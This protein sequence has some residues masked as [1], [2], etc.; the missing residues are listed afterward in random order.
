VTKINQKCNAM[1]WDMETNTVSSQNFTNPHYREKNGKMEKLTS[2]RDIYEINANMAARRLRARILAVL[3]NYFVDD[4]INECKKTLAGKNDEPLADR[5]KRMIVQ[6]EKVGVTQE[7]IEKRSKCD[8][9]ALTADDFVDYVGIYN[10]LKD[11][12]SSI[13]DWFE[14]KKQ[15]KKASIVDI[16]D[17]K[18]ESK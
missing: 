11:K 12:Q 18:T 15:E 14:V 10:S 2:D 7:M 3:P 9:S 5:V 8:I 16:I 1:A 17:D 6:F 4:C 13:A